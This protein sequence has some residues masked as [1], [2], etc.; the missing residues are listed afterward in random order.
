MLAGDEQERG[1]PRPPPSIP[2]AHGPMAHVGLT[3]L[4]T[5]RPLAEAATPALAWEGGDGGQDSSAA[6]AP[7]RQSSCMCSLGN[8]C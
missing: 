4:C 3:L 2:M 7:L 8:P 6:G 1:N 5:D